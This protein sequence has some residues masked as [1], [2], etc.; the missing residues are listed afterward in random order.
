MSRTTTHRRLVAAVI[1]LLS[2][3]AVH[4]Q[5][6]PDTP[7]RGPVRPVTVTL[8]VEGGYGTGTYHPGE[9]VAIVAAVPT[10]QT[11]D[12]WLAPQGVVDVPTSATNAVVTMPSTPVTVTATFKPRK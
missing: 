8:T 6:R 9:R 11:F 7:P 4:A 5:Q 3:A 1:V 10:G 2:T 12:H